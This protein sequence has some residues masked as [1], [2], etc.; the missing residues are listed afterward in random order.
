MSNVNNQGTGYFAKEYLAL[1]NVILDK[2]V[3]ENNEYYENY[4]KKYFR[5]MS[6]MFNMIDCELD[7]HS[8]YVVGYPLST[9]TK[10]IAV[11]RIY[12]F[13]QTENSLNAPYL[14][15]DNFFDNYYVMNIYINET[16]IGQEDME[17]AKNVAKLRFVSKVIDEYRKISDTLEDESLFVL[18][19]IHLLMMTKY[20]RLLCDKDADLHRF[21]DIILPE[22]Y[23]VDWL[24]CMDFA[25]K[26]DKAN[27][28]ASQLDLK[29]EIFE[30]IKSSI[31]K[32]ELYINEY[33]R[34]YGTDRCIYDIDKE[35][36]LKFLIFGLEPFSTKEISKIWNKFI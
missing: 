9:N 5:V 33:L 26:N 29:A 1:Q 10:F 32:D 11:L 14:F 25:D 23:N 18:T 28:F 22:L 20:S 31:S 15:V 36:I 21:D 3:D 35:L 7:S 30:F 4:I 12:L 34:L 17:N 6:K 8:A 19:K 24:K 13:E 27:C 2:E 16:R